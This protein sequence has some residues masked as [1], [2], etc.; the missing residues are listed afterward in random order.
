MCKSIS[1][2]E[3]Q[4]PVLSL[5]FS[6]FATIASLGTAGDNFVAENRLAKPHF[7]AAMD[8]NSSN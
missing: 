3:C 4:A 1:T 6:G 5:Y 8:L 2:L 7:S